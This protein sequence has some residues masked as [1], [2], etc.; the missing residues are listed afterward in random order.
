M[1]KTIKSR[2]AV[3]AMSAAIAACGSEPVDIAGSLAN[4]NG[5]TSSGN[6]SGGGSPNPGTNP[7]TNPSAAAREWQLEH[8]HS[9]P[10]RTA[11]APNV[12]IDDSGFATAIW[13]EADGI[14]AA[15]R[16]PQGVWGSAV[17]LDSGVGRLFARFVPERPAI[18]SANGRAVAVWAQHD[19]KEESMFASVFNQ[20]QWSSAIALEQDDTRRSSSPQV[21][22]DDQGNAMA[23]WYMTRS[24]M[25]AD[26]VTSRFS[27]ASRS[28]G[29]A[30]AIN[31]SPYRAV[32]NDGHTVFSALTVSPAGQFHLV[33]SR[34]NT[35]NSQD[36]GTMH[37]QFLGSSWTTST[38][39][40]RGYT[41]NISLAFERVTG[42]LI[43]SWGRTL[44]DSN[45]LEFARL[46]TT[47]W[48]LTP[49]NDAFDQPV[50]G[51]SITSLPGGRV[52]IAWGSRGKLYTRQ[53]KPVNGWGRVVMVHDVGG[54]R[55]Q[56]V[57][58]AVGDIVLLWRSWHNF[59]SYSA[60]GEN[61]TLPNMPFGGPSF[62]RGL[63]TGNGH[64][65]A[66][67][68]EGDAVV[69]WND[70]SADSRIQSSSIK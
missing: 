33:W 65:I 69:I 31:V 32:T 50:S 35:T 11:I 53:F 36:G 29:T 17:R 13:I 54:E 58:D 5:G 61:W 47:G 6:T 18:A 46:E 27:A 34:V 45:Q 38:L 30:Q 70:P 37:S 43:A 55:P 4:Q 67:N 25:P 51:T 23:A 7:S 20:G 26:L 19:G 66:M 3:L 2:F 28:W 62:A 21:V 44:A 48:K 10:F 41:R 56:V 57:A 15:R 16:T 39:I 9:V 14:Y 22:M 52:L 68:T 40:N 63:N 64:Q 42:R 12:T 59:T 60:D 8:N 24:G 1:K 49:L